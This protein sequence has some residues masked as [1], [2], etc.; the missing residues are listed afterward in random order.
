MGGNEWIFTAE[1]L[2][3]ARKRANDQVVATL[4]R[5]HKEESATGSKATPEKDPPQA[6]GPD[7][8]SSLIL[9][10][11]QKVPDLCKASGVLPGAQWTAVVFFRRFYASHSPMEFDPLAMTFTCTFV[12]CKVEEQHDIT[13][14]ALLDVGGE[15]VSTDKGGIGTFRKKVLAL[16]LPLL[17]GVGF[18]LFVEPKLHL[19]LGLLVDELRGQ[20][21]ESLPCDPANLGRVRDRA[22]QMAMNLTVRSDAVLRW[23]PSVLILA[24]LT[25]ALEE[26]EEEEKSKVETRD[27]SNPSSF[28]RAPTRSAVSSVRKLWEAR[29]DGSDYQTE[30]LGK[31]LSEVV[32]EA[33]VASAPSKEPKVSEALRNAARRQRRC[34]KIFERIRDDAAL[35]SDARHRERKRKIGEQKGN[36][37]G[38]SLRSLLGIAPLGDPDGDQCSKM[39]FT[40]PKADGGEEEFI[41]RRPKDDTFGDAAI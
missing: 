15:A 40:P 7:E 26:E 27:L 24:A 10:Y 4:E 16:E 14:E 3:R 38:R 22:E 13:L 12:A 19:T 35:Q 33:R 30:V 11:V 39:G 29:M 36:L 8:E 18:Q 2:A 31:A 20:P 41:I 6:L 23:K 9:H 32:D 5:A 28:T 34:L 1:G 25:C 17:E 21:P 37:R